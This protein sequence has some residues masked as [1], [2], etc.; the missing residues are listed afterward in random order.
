M[1]KRLVRC[2]LIAFCVG[3][4]PKELGSLSKLEKLVLSVNELAGEKGSTALL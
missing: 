3:A 2:F 1:L 4:V